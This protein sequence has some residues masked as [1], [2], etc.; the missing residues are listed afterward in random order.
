[1]TFS[2]HLLGGIV[3]LVIGLLLAWIIF[4]GIPNLDPANSAVIWLVCLIV[5]PFAGFLSG[6]NKM[7]CALRR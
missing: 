5:L 3:G 1:M 2:D 7:L 6:L 4:S